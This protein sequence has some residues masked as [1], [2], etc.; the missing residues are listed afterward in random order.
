MNDAMG[1]AAPPLEIVPLGGLGEFGMNMMVV[2]CGDT[3]IVVDAGVM[4]PEPELLGV[5]LIIPDLRY[6]QQDKLSRAGADAR[7]RG[8]H[9]R[10]RPRAPARRRPG[11]RHA[12][13]AGAGRAEARGARAST[14]RSAARHRAPAR[15]RDR[16]AR[17]RSSSSGSRTA[18]PTAWRSPSTRRAG[19]VLHTGDFKI[20][21]TPLDGEHFD[22]HRFAELGIG[23][24]CSRCSPTARTSI[25]RG[26]TG[27][28][29]EV[30]DG[31]EEIFTS[32]HRQG[33]SSRCSR[34]A[35]TGCRSSW[36]WRR[37]SS[38]KVAFVGRGVIENSE[39]AQRLGYLGCPAG[40]LIRDSD[41]RSYPRRTCSASATGSQGEPHG[42]AL[43]HRHRRP[44]P[45]QARA[46]T[47]RWSSRRARSPATRRRSGA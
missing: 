33:S 28:E 29:L 24:A 36:T 34:R 45:R 37:S 23:R 3:T 7:A 1:A 16:S 9:R 2:A 12:A 30:I 43:A 20:D 46:R 15:P 21:Q 44:P 14:A 39:I 31:F 13:D 18:S 41:V 38:G 40:M 47:T 32:A 5:D 6:L 11:L 22:F 25:A 42:G 27:S 10:G 19:I 17:S 4:F 35:S 26:F 8:P